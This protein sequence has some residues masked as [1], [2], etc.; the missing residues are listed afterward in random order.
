MLFKNNQGKLPELMKIV[1]SIDKERNGY[2]TQTEL[3]D[4]LKHIFSLPKSLSLT[5]KEKT[6]TKSNKSEKT[7]EK[8]WFKIMVPDA[9]S[10]PRTVMVH[11]QNTSFAYFAVM[12]SVRFPYIAFSAE[13]IFV[14][15]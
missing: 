4:I 13:L 5:P 11:V 12:S 7:I 1:N 14:Y 8:K 3:D 10:H 2:V 9:V 6:P 15:L